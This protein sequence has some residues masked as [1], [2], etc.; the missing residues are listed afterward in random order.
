[1]DAVIV[2][3]IAQTLIK[4]IPYI[5]VS[6]SIQRMIAEVV[7]VL[8]LSEYKQ[9]FSLQGTDASWERYHLGS[10]PILSAAAVSF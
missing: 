3:H 10:Y 5:S 2:S 6:M 4:D 7:Y 9:G 8:R 1:M